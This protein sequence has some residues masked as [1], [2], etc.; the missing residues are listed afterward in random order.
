MLTGADGAAGSAIPAGSAGPAGS[1]E[2]AGARERGTAG[3]LIL[4][5]T[6]PRVAPGLLTLSAWDTL[7][8]AA[9]VLCGSADHPQL[10]ALADAGITAGILA[11]PASA[12]PVPA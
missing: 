9:R 4:L 5:V 8:G 7:R 11:V 12:G 2:P 1:G 6:S 10:P 3:E